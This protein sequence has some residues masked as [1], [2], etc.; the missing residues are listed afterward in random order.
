[1]P[2]LRV[3]DVSEQMYI[4]RE[5]Q[6]AQD[7]TL[8][9]WLIHSQKIEMNREAVITSEKWEGEVREERGEPR[10]KLKENE[11]RVGAKGSNPQEVINDLHDQF[12]WSI[13]QQANN[14]NY[15]LWLKSTNIYWLSQMFSPLSN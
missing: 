9:L 6:R 7:L 13:M 8:E 5:E 14:Q 15:F 10:R 1:M 4:V 11:N 12:Y 3:Y 2:S